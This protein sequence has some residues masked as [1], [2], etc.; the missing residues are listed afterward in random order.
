MLKLCLGI[1]WSIAWAC[2]AAAGLPPDNRPPPPEHPLRR[3]VVQRLQVDGLAVVEHQWCVWTGRGWIPLM[4]DEGQSRVFGISPV[5]RH[6]IMP[7]PPIPKRQRRL[8]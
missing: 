2:A 4:S 8:E 6:P 5:L 1:A 7:A 3:C